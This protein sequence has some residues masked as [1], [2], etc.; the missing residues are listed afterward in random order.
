[1]YEYNAKLLRIVDGDTVDVMI[2]LGLYCHKKERLR[3]ADIN[4]PERYQEGGKEATA[5]LTKLLMPCM[6]ISDQ[7]PQLLKIRTEKQ[8]KFG[9]WIAWLYLGDEVYSINK[10]MVDAGH[11]TLYGKKAEG[12]KGAKDTGKKT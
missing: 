6:L 12:V 5:Y 4:A 2:D 11:A 1:M 8:G 9:R 7:E 3:L 10:K